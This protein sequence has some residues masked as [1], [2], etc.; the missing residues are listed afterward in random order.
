VLNLNLDVEKY[1]DDIKFNSSIFGRERSLM[2]MMHALL[3][4]QFP[5]EQIRGFGEYWRNMEVAKYG[6]IQADSGFRVYLYRDMGK[7]KRE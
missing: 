3:A 5:F 1:S 2:T 7:S 6:L 4:V